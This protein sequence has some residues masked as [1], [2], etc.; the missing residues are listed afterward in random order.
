MEDDFRILQIPLALLVRDSSNGPFTVYSHVFPSNVSSM[1]LFRVRTGSLV[2][3]RNHTATRLLVELEV[4][5]TLT[6]LLG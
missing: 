6:F 2:M 4:H 1:V 3:Y 5:G